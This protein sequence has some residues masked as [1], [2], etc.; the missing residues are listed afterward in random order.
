MNHFKHYINGMNRHART[1]DMKD[2]MRQAAEDRANTL[3][4]FDAMHEE[5]IADWKDYV[6]RCGGTPISKIKP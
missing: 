1:A 6:K 2:S 5:S 4:A 3:A